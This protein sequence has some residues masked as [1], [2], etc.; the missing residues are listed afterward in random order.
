MSES[1]DITWNV[2]V[3]TTRWLEGRGI[4]LSTSSRDHSTSSQQL[5]RPEFE[6]STSECRLLLLYQCRPRRTNGPATLGRPL[7]PHAQGRRHLVQC[8][9]L[10]LCALGSIGAWRYSA[11]SLAHSCPQQFQLNPMTRHCQLSLLRMHCPN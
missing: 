11:T 2:F 8:H 1:C 6:A 7:S 10:S 5:F 9:S 3:G 4:L